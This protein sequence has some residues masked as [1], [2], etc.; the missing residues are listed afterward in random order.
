MK[1]ARAYSRYSRQAAALLGELI[2]KARLEQR[3]PESALAERA[4]ISRSLLQRIEKGDMGVSIGAAFEA[5]TIVGV[6]L[7]E[8]EPSRLTLASEQTS[9]ML[10]LLPKAARSPSTK[11]VKDDF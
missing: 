10:R 8:D 9:A 1:R 2:R 5:A 7:F 11:S 3:L 4:G 6:T